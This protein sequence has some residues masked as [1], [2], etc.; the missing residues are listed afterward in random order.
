MTIAAAYL[1]SEGVVLGADSTTTVASRKGIKQLL[2]HAQKVFEIGEHGRIG[3]C[4]YGAGRV[5]S[6][7]HRTLLARLGD[8]LTDQTVR[9]TS[10]QLAQLVLEASRNGREL[11]DSVGYYVG[12]RNPISREPACCHVR[13]TPAGEVS[14]DELGIGMAHFSGQ[15]SIFNRVFHGFDEELPHRLF[16]ALLVELDADIQ[17]GRIEKDDLAQKFSKAFGKSREGLTV[18]GYNDL[19]IREAIDY[20]HAYL[21]VTIKAFKFRSGPPVCG[22]PI[23]IGFITTDRAFRWVTHKAFETAMMDHAP[24]LTRRSST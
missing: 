11:G 9:Q 4:T 24:L 12:G 7:S 19:P 10:H 13:I 6:S 23:E 21:H 3:A 20:V 17:A 18:A 16:A 22:G 2:N 5:G 15:Y 1:T 14:I 8:W